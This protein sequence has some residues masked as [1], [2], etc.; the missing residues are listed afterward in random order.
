MKSYT[1]CVLRRSCSSSSSTPV[2]RRAQGGELLD[3]KR[4]ARAAG[5]R[6]EDYP[7][8]IGRVGARTQGG[9]EREE[10]HDARHARV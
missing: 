4:R 5:A 8:L 3:K 10:S 7:A 2:R 6:D 1:I 9:G